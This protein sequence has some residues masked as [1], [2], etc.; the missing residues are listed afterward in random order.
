MHAEQGL[1]AES[2]MRVQESPSC[3]GSSFALSLVPWSC[4]MD[5][6]QN[7]LSCTPAYLLLTKAA[8]ERHH[9]EQTDM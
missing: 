5:T 2:S 7:V 4:L 3:S 1:I 9:P 6:S 8:G